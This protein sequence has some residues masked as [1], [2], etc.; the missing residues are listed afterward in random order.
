MR[1]IPNYPDYL[2]SR[3]GY[4]ISLKHGKERI[5]KA[6]PNDR[7]W[8]CVTLYNNDV[9]KR[10][11]VHRLVAETYIDNPYNLPTVDHIDRDKSN[12]HVDN[13]RWASVSEQNYNRGPY[14]KPRRKDCR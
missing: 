5:I 12:N 14:T 10:L 2:I 8:L 1:R 7:G 9:K 6:T 4:I 11:R 3:L 13:L